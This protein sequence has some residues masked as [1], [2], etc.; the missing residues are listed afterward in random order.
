MPALG[1]VLLQ[2]AENSDPA[3][4]WSDAQI[5]RQHLTSFHQEFELTRT[6]TSSGYEQSSKTRLIIDGAGTRW[7]S[8]QVTG[9]GNRLTLFDGEDRSIV[10]NFLQQRPHEFPVVLSSENNLPRAYQIG[11]FPTYIVIDSDGTVAT[12]VEGEQGFADLRSKLK[13]A[14]LDRD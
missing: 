4:V 9:S 11:I 8:E 5:R 2:A 12:A 7:R 1:G 6:V 3:R 10:E 14:G 13:K